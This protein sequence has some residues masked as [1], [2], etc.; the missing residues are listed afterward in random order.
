MNELIQSVSTPHSVTQWF[1]RNIDRALRYPQLDLL[2]VDES[3]PPHENRE[4]RQLPNTCYT[5]VH[6]TRL[7]SPVLVC[8]AKRA[9][10]QCLGLDVPDD[11]HIRDA[12][13]RIV[14]GD[15][16][17][18]AH[19]LP[20][21]TPFAHRYAGHQFGHFAR[22]LGDGRAISLGML[23]GYELQLKGSGKTPFSRFGDGR[24]VLFSSIREFLGSEAT[25]ALRIAT[26]RAAVLVASHELKVLREHQA[27]P[28]AVLLRLSRG[29]LR[30]GSLETCFVDAQHAHLVG[31]LD[32]V[33]AQHYAEAV[34]EA[35]E[36]DEQNRYE[37]FWR[38]LVE[39]TARLAAGWKSVGFV[40]GVLNTDNLSLL[41]EAI[42]FGPFGFVE[43]FDENFVPNHSDRRARY[44]W[45]AQEAALKWS[46]QRLALA[47]DR[48]GVLPTEVSLKYLSGADAADVE[49]EAKQNEN[50]E[51]P[52]PYQAT[53]DAEQFA[54]FVR[55][56]EHRGSAYIRELCDERGRNLLHCAVINEAP[57]RVLSDLV[58][59]LGVDVDALDGDGRAALFYAVSDK[60]E[61]SVA[62]L[63]A[64]GASVALRS[65]DLALSVY[66]AKAYVCGGRGVLHQVAETGALACG[67]LILQHMRA[68]GK[69]RAALIL[70]RDDNGRTAMHVA[71][72]CGEGA[73]L[74]M[75]NAF[76][77]AHLAPHTDLD[78]LGIVLCDELSGEAQR[79]EMARAYTLAVRQRIEKAKQMGES[80]EALGRFSVAK[81]PRGFDARFERYFTQKLREKFGFLNE[82]AL[83]KVR[84]MRAW[85]FHT[86]QRTC[87]DFTNVFRNLNRISIFGV[88]ILD[89][90]GGDAA[91]R[92]AAEDG[93][94][95]DFAV[96]QC[97]SLAMYAKM[98]YRATLQTQIRQLEAQL[99]QGADEGVAQMVRAAKRSSVIRYEAEAHEVD[100]LMRREMADFGGDE[101]AKRGRDRIL[102]TRFVRRYRERVNGEFAHGPPFDAA[103]VAQ[104]RALDGRRR[105]LMDGANPKYILRNYLMEQAIQRAKHKDYAMV[106]QL[107]AMVEKP[108]ASQHFADV[109]AFTDPVPL[110]ACG[111]CVSCAS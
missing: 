111:L 8:V 67:R 52:F 93:E 21:C 90:L 1:D 77:R 33:I 65:R 95:V 35:A 68:T 78:A 97:A 41:G 87:C 86:L 48:I 101:A 76:V 98:G 109:H 58:S 25:H 99:A 56:H 60:S 23:G 69:E 103:Q 37:L 50:D 61:R 6:P 31:L 110:E 2:S 102:W 75:L 51:A 91:A 105:A 80:K 20:R 83:D 100:A 108:F 9:L 92:M 64:Q 66:V 4:P 44:S 11:A 5:K 17:A 81:T 15:M 59:R 46:L 28:T 63:L 24:A 42:D 72:M 73:A 94:F 38:A 34:R 18:L 53:A 29:F 22:Q 16:S 62:A 70:R 13:T 54:A 71:D 14:G 49:D 26:S 27:E 85:M 57:P 107:L 47:L 39:R 79:K 3:K 104:L 106:E 74:R 40:H 32:F 96:S 82:G 55:A 12:L 45:C 10:Q 19:L 30:F 43:Y 89:E 7:P 36:T 84:E 88:G